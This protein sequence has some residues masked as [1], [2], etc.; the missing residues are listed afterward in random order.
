MK[1]DKLIKT[2]SGDVIK[3]YYN[4]RPI[5]LLKKKTGT[6]LATHLKETEKKKTVNKTQYIRQLIVIIL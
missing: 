2:I 4:R 5:K 1:A 6:Q 3:F